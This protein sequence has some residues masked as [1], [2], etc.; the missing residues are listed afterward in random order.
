VASVLSLASAGMGLVAMPS[1]ALA[2]PPACPGCHVIDNGNG[3]EHGYIS[4][5]PEWCKYVVTPS[6]QTNEACH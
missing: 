5:P 2:D 4:V 1:V 3:A 6:D